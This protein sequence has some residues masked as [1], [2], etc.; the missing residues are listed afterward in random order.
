[1]TKVT[2]QA[3]SHAVMYSLYETTHGGLTPQILI[4]FT[5]S[6]NSLKLESANSSSINLT[7]CPSTFQ[8]QMMLL[9]YSLR[10]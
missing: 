2:K 1:M 9:C 4:D 8:K 3:S 5:C 6:L 10:Y 7:Y